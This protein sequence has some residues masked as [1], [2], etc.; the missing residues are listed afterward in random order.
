M[1]SLFSRQNTQA[2]K[3]AKSEPLLSQQD[4]PLRDQFLDLDRSIFIENNHIESYLTYDTWK[5]V[6]SYF[7]NFSDLETMA[8][9]SDKIIFNFLNKDIQLTDRL[10]KTARLH[11]QIDRLIALRNDID[12]QVENQL[13]ILR[14]QEEKRPVKKSTFARAIGSIISLIPVSTLVPLGL[15]KFSNAN[16]LQLLQNV[17]ADLACACTSTYDQRPV[18]C[19]D[20]LGWEPRECEYWSEKNNNGD[21]EGCTFVDS[22]Y[23]NCSRALCNNYYSYCEPISK[24][25]T[26]GNWMIVGGAIWSAVSLCCFLALPHINR[27]DE[28][29][30]KKIVTRPFVELFEPD[31]QERV[32]VFLSL[33]K[34][35]IAKLSVIKISTEVTKRLDQAKSLLLSQ[36]ELEQLKIKLFPHVKVEIDIA[37]DSSRL[38]NSNRASR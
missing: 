23:Y 18:R 34:E 19:N 25:N 17:A 3:D 21:Y 24:N 29:P 15:Q 30:L 10:I 38:E 8:L 7:S 37:D 9:L 5:I 28:I 1:F 14:E 32:G 22:Y 36:N 33:R 4:E 27:L 11:F 31:I 6:L 20:Y 13:Q 35:D 12:A 16:S 2:N 26:G